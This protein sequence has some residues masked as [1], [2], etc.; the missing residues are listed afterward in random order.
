MLHLAKV[1]FPGI[2]RGLEL[3]AHVPAPVDSRYRSQQSPEQDAE[4]PILQ[5]V[6]DEQQGSLGQRRQDGRRQHLLAASAVKCEVGEELQIVILGD[7][8]RHRITK[9]A[10]QVIDKR[11]VRLW[12]PAVLPAE[13]V[14]G[15]GHVRVPGAERRVRA[16]SHGLQ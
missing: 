10:V 11:P 16:F 13:E 9:A 8:D 7:H 5:A 14:P 12:I 4:S 1:R 2:G 6:A 3:D 15:I